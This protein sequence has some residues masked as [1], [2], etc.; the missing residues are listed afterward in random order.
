MSFSSLV[1]IQSNMQINFHSKSF[2]TGFLRM[3]LMI[4]KYLSKTV[5]HFNKESIIVILN[6]HIARVNTTPSGF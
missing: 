3:F 6:L 4:E 1:C 5:L 2:F